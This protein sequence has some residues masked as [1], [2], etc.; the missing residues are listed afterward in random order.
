MLERGLQRG[1]LKF[2]G[3][4]VE[5]QL[6]DFQVAFWELEELTRKCVMGNN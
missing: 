1:K 2:K 5:E 3:E 6:G 4:E